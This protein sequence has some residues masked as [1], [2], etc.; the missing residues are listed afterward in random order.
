MSRRLTLKDV[1]ELAGVSRATASLVVRNS[2]LVAEKTRQKVLKAIEK[3]GYKYNRVAASFRSQKSGILALILPSISNPFFAEMIAGI[4]SIVRPQDYSVQIYLSH[5]NSAHQYEIL[6]V[7]EEYQVDGIFI[8]P[9][10]GSDDSLFDRIS[11]LNIP[12]VFIT[13]HLSR[14]DIHYVGVNN[15]KGS[16]IGTK[17]LLEKGHR[18]IAYI[19]G[20]IDSSARK[21]RLEGYCCSL[22]EAGIRYKKEL[23]QPSEINIRGGFQSLE[24]ILAS[25][26]L[27]AAICYND[28]V[29]LGVSLAASRFQRNIAVI[30]FDNIPQ[31]EFWIP[32]LTTVCVPAQEIGE[33]A[34]RLLLKQLTEDAPIQQIFLDPKIYI[35]ESA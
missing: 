16:R 17:Y 22:E 28:I 23:V 1:A 25:C 29:A 7:I 19:G 13:R 3:S 8:C 26:E 34:V 20:H 4:E 32:S 12:Y 15:V 14:K 9:A 35:R 33:Q 2:P 24:K 5:E 11:Q 21:E 27:D 6:R 10:Q 18:N 30:G 31:A